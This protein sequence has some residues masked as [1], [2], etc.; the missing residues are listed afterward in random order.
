MAD[1]AII[2]VSDCSSEK[3]DK[4]KEIEKNESSEDK[5]S[6]L[7]LISS[8]VNNQLQPAVESSHDV[9]HD[10]RPVAFTF[11]RVTILKR[12]QTPPVENTS[13]VIPKRN[14]R[15][16]KEREAAY[17][18]ARLRILG[19]GAD[20]SEED[21]NGT[22]QP[23]TKSV[24]DSLLGDAVVA[25][26]GS[27]GIT[28]PVTSSF[29]GILNHLAPANYCVASAN[30]S[31]VIHHQVPNFSGIVQL[32]PV[33][34]NFPCVFQP[35][36]Q[37]FPCYVPSFVPNFSS[38][39]PPSGR[40]FATSMPHIASSWPNVARH[41]G[42]PIKKSR[43]QMPVSYSV[44]AM[45]GDLTALATPVPSTDVCLRNQGI[46]LTTVPQNSGHLANTDTLEHTWKR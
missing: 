43:P 36:A 33:V 21:S 15:T 11:D 34:P 44:P 17:S 41:K 16:L 12:Q 1:T 35:F 45:L 25:T 14:I 28:K 20:F 18:E 9:D 26:S 8:G 10:Q 7:A 30:F 38:V 37:N 40:N 42:Q 22:D 39:V 29:S 32:Q 6:D 3:C 4:V 5:A 19:T 2:P 27:S 46:L 13:Q 31:G 24:T 23:V